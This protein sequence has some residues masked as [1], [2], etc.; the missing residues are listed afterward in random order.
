M[1]FKHIWKTFIIVSD[2]EEYICFK[3]TKRT[4]RFHY[5]DIELQGIHVYVYGIN[6][7]EKYHNTK[8]QT[9]L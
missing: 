9:A 2:L 4:I 7:F 6:I 8:V 3:I 1:H 5:V